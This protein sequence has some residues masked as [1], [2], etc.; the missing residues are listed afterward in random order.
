MR[1]NPDKTQGILLNGKNR[2][3]RQAFIDRNGSEIAVLH[4]G[5]T[6]RTE[7]SYVEK[8]KKDN[9]FLHKGL[10]YNLLFVFTEC[11]NLNKKQT[12]FILNFCH[13]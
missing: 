8:R 6:F 3:L 4:L 13:I 7:K 10:N 1:S 9:R 11:L 5:I 12:L 2:T